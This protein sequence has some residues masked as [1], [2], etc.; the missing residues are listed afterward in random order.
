MSGHPELFQLRPCKELPTAHARAHQIEGMASLHVE[1]KSRFGWINPASHCWSS[2]QRSCLI[3][4]G[5]WSL[6][7]RLSL[8]KMEAAL[9]V[10][11]CN[12]SDRTI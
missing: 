11:Y 12:F 6:S 4:S 9:R 3:D 7:Y 2:F 1:N 10:G 5:R 8:I